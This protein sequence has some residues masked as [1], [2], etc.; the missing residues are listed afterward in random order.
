MGKAS[1]KKRGITEEDRTDA[2]RS[3]TPSKSSKQEKF[4]QKRFVHILL[5]VV[6]GFLAYSNTFDSP[7]QWDDIKHI[8]DNSVIKDLGNFTA[9]TKGYNFNPRRVVG[10]FTFALNYH[11]GGTDVTGYHVVNLLIHIANAFLVYAFVML[12]FQTP[13]FR[14]QNAEV[15]TQNAEVRNQK[16]DKNK[17][18]FKDGNNSAFCILH[19]DFKNGS[20]SLIALFSALLFVSHP[21]QTQ[22][23]TYIVQRFT[24]LAA[25][26]YLLS[27]ALYIKGR[28]GAMGNGQWAPPPSPPL[29]RGELKGGVSSISYRL[30][31]IP[32]F[33]LSF[34]FAVLAMK[35]K[36]IT[37]TLP[38]MIVLYEFVFF[39]AS[40]RKK[41]LFILPVLLML[42]II[43]L[44]LIHTERSLGDLLSEV[45]AK[46]RIQTQMPRMDYFLTQLRVV[47]T[48]IRL[49]L[50]PVNQNFDYD[51]PIYRS[52]FTPPVLL[53]FLF[54][55][56]LFGAAVYLLYRSRVVGAGL[57]PARLQGGQPQELP[58]QSP[59][60]LTLTLSPKGRGEDGG[61]DSLP[62]RGMQGDDVSSP[63]A[64]RLSPIAY[65]RLIA[66]GILWFFLALS[67]ESSF[68]PIV[69]VIFEHRVYLPSSGFLIS[70]TAGL[71]LIAQRFRMEKIALTVL[72]LTTLIFT[73]ASYSRNNVWESNVSLWEDVVEKSPNKARGHNNLGSFYSEKGFNDKAIREFQ[74]ALRLDPAYAD[75]HSSLGAV[76]AEQGRVDEAINEFQAALL[77]DPDFAD[78]HYNLGT[79]YYS[80]G[81][82]AEAFK[83]FE[84]AVRTKPDYAKAHNNLGAIYQAEGRIDEALNEYRLA[85]KYDPGLASARKNYKNLS[86]KISQ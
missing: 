34:V 56:A 43:P 29:A 8:G 65:Y 53:S 67:V 4:L 71:F 72:I 2:S 76:Y 77:I 21:V 55:A 24:S 18:S 51:Y 12:T 49:L 44:S 73:G 17:T 35:T 57:V 59:E 63:I 62:V 50:F 70:V 38:L 5:I 61:G 78:A 40:M 28:L 7:F 3:L 58:L 79:A 45:S 15:R 13:Y 68:I 54:L 11:F 32:W 19:S 83:E 41:L 86:E 42:L 85:L 23:V 10:Y 20:R 9:S 37:L 46:T 66:F 16:S 27:V 25:M 84:A 39:K 75:S 31:P 82:M 6:L 69:D 30:S 64:Y 36:E 60:P 47:T 80:R 81:R 22:A 33:F 48:Y 1:R 26:F 14:S 74:A 52:F